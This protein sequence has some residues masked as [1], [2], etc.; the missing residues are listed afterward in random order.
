MSRVL[1][2][3]EPTREKVFRGLRNI[4][5]LISIK[6]RTWTK[7]LQSN[8]KLKDRV[9]ARAISEKNR[10]EIRHESEKSMNCLTRHFVWRRKGEMSQI[11]DGFRKRRKR[12][13]DVAQI[14]V[15]VTNVDESEGSQS[16]GTIFD[17]CWQ[18]IKI[19]GNVTNF[20]WPKNSQ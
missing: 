15:V 7:M 10:V 2:E 6:S 12:K 19:P 5:V 8:K 4:L 1:E 3:K 18:P 11:W 20:E 9:V 13:V 17:D 16:V 14:K